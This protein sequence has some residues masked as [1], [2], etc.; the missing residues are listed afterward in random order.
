MFFLNAEIILLRIFKINIG[1]L[2]NIET[3]TYVKL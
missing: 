3:I 2:G 1:N